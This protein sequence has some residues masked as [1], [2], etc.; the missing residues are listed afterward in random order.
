MV[1]LKE[2]TLL[3]EY[4]EDAVFSSDKRTIHNNTYP[5]GIF[6][7]KKLKSVTFNNITI[8]YGGNG[9][10]KTTLLN[11]IANKLKANRKSIINKGNYFDIYVSKCTYEN[12]CR[13]NFLYL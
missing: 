12:R 11:I 10:G 4:E 2:F 5:L 13:N 1:Y 7:N 6:I 3:S 9:S 8:F